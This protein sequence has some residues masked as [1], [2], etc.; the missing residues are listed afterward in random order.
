MD[1]QAAQVQG[2]VVFKVDVTGC[3]GVLLW[4]SCSDA[5]RSSLAMGA[6]AQIIHCK[7]VG[8]GGESRAFP[9]PLESVSCRFQEWNEVPKVHKCRINRTRVGEIKV[10]Y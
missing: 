5:T 1:A 4:V 6:I 10:K 2:D 9:H 7:Q 3:L 8:G